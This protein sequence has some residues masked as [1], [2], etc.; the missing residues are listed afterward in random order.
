MKMILYA[1][2]ACIGSNGFKA[3]K[4]NDSVDGQAAGAIGF[5]C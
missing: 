2:A 5:I 3:K 4:A 1:M